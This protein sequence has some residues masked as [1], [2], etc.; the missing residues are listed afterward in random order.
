MAE[1]QRDAAPRLVDGHIWS[2]DGGGEPLRQL[3]DKDSYRLCAAGRCLIA[4]R[5][6]VVVG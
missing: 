3:A 1:L 4:A 2:R 5:A 6:S